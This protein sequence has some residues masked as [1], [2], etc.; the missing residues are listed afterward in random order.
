MTEEQRLETI[1]MVNADPGAR[2]YMLSVAIAYRA[3][4]L[5]ESELARARRTMEDL[6]VAA[7]GESFV[8]WDERTITTPARMT[9]HEWQSHAADLIEQTTRQ[10]Q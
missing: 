6:Q 7:G 2:A 4:E 5:S 3:S 9:F 8:G 1:A 10:K